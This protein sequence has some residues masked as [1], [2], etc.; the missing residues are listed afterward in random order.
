MSFTRSFFATPLQSKV[1]FFQVD[2]ATNDEKLNGMVKGEVVDI[3]VDVPKLRVGDQI[4]TPY[5]LTISSSMVDHWHSAFYNH[6]R[7]NTSTPYA[8]KLGLQDSVLPFSMMLFLCG[9]MSHADSAKVQVG[10][11]NSIYHWPG[12]AGD[13]FTKTFEVRSVRNVSD[14]RHAIIKFNCGL[15]NQRG[16]VCMS[17]DKTMLF[18][19]KSSSSS[20]VERTPQT[21]NQAFRAHLMSKAEV[22]GDLGSTTLTPLRPGQMIVHSM[23]RALSLSQSQQLA[24]LARLT[25]PRH[26]NSKKY[27]PK[28][29]IFIPGGLILGLVHSASA[30]DLHEIIHEEAASVSYINNVHPTDIVGAVTYVKSLE[31]NVS[32]DMEGLTVTT[33]GIKNI[34]PDELQGVEFPRELFARDLTKRDVERICK[35][36]IPQLSNKIVLQTERKLV[37][38][39]TRSEAFLL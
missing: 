36:S 27:D 5:E 32:G 13:T 31:E 4:S 22:L 29:E 17:T 39:A 7:I 18:E 37:R 20:T 21:T 10:F 3:S 34:D 15:V 1:D 38:Q 26:F 14:G 30:R 16:R 12:F 28:T 19:V 35:E 2:N 9:S 6:D 23:C 8:R 11:E 24:S 25:H 33:I